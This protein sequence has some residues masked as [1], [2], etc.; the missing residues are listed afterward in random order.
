MYHHYAGT[1]HS[2]PIYVNTPYHVK[3]V[4]TA[5]GVVVKRHSAYATIGYV[6]FESKYTFSYRSGVHWFVRASYL[7]GD[8]STL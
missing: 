3:F 8:V 1:R 2:A 7:I 6:K 5:D 4:N